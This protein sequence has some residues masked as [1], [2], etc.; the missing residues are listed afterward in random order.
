MA[1]ESET[2]ISSNFK[3]LSKAIEILQS[4]FNN[5]DNDK[6]KTKIMKTF[7]EIISI[8]DYFQFLL[9][10]QLNNQQICHEL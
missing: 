10:L 1:N 6:I 4:V 3:M 7:E 9:N 8:S 2:I 5:I